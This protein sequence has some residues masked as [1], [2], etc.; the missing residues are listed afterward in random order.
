MDT[1]LSS[2]IHML[3]LISE[4]QTPMSSEQIA[5][6]VG[7]NPS[8]IRKIAGLLKNANI[9]DSRQG[10]S[11]FVLTV[12]PEEL[13]LWRVYC[14]VEETE[15]IHLFDL[16]RNPNDECIVGRHIRPTLA[17]M[18]GDIEA[19]AQ[20]EMKEKTLR[21]CMNDMQTRINQTEGQS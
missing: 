13:S 21:D 17:A 3:I 1:K 5:V 19:T 2:A 4:A 11:G 6:S 9:I 8:Y 10:K 20:R 15:Q 12:A 16:H 7:T 14:A 18:F